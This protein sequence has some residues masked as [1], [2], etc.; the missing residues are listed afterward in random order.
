MLFFKSRLISNIWQNHKVKISQTYTLNIIENVSN[1]LLPAASGLLIDG[2]IAKKMD[3]LWFFI[4]AYVFWYGTAMIRRVYDT[5]VFTKIYN[6]VSIKT[7]VHHQE[8]NIDSGT[9]NAR[10]ELLKQMVNF[11]E[12]DMPFLMNNLIQMFGA[13]VLL[14]FYDPK[15]MVVCLVVILPSFA[16][17]YFFGKK[18]LSVATEVNDKYEQQLE[19]IQS[20]ANESSLVSYFNIVRKLN[21]RKSNLEAWNFGILEIFVLL[22]IIASLYMICQNPLLKHGDIVAIYG[23]ITRFAYSFDFIPHLTAKLSVVKD[24]ENRLKEVV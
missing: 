18:M 23:Y 15:V 14:Y 12:V 19:M 1:M 8:E 13:F 24:I 2:F 7:I 11:F 22:M 10:I 4:A 3:G 21:I 20:K 5:K 6:D 16:I 17:N 9:I